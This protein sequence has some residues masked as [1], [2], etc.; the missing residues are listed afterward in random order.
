MWVGGVLTPLFLVVHHQLLGLTD[1]EGEEVV[2]APH[3]QV[4]DLLPVGF[5]IIAGDQAYYRQCR[6]QT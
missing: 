5:L 3:C 4:T 2:V 1:V 6:E